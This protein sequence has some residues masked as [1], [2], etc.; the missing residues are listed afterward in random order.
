MGR[1][2]NE[3]LGSVPEKRKSGRG[4]EKKSPDSAMPFFSIITWDPIIP[5]FFAHFSTSE[6]SGRHSI[7]IRPCVFLS[8]TRD[9]LPLPP[10]PSLTISTSG[11]SGSTVLFLPPLFPCQ[12]AY[13]EEGEGRS[14]FPFFL[15]EGCR[16]RG[17]A[18]F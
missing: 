3:K 5:S 10:F 18:V 17:K 9:L 12:P 4:E 16:K 2:N 11:I 13:G 1:E 8:S 7:S 14:P 6:R 15:L